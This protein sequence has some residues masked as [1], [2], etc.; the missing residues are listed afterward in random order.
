ML[1]SHGAQPPLLQLAM[2]DIHIY[3]FLLHRVKKHK[4][5]SKEC[6]IT[7]GGGGDSTVITVIIFC[8]LFNG[9][10]VTVTNF[11]LQSNRYFT[12]LHCPPMHITL[13]KAIC[14]EQAHN[15][16]VINVRF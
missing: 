8:C 15:Y 4:K 12:K 11:L 5:R 14:L 7:A 1:L 3:L 16:M 10:N 6:D 13:T 2:Q 9:N